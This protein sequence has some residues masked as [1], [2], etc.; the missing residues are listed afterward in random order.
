[1]KP[2]TKL[3]ACALLFL[4]PATSKAQN[5]GQIQ[6]ARAGD[7]AYLYSS[8]T[9][10]EVRAKLQCGEE[11][12]VLN[13][14]D[15]FLF[16]RTDKGDTGYVPLESV[17]MLK[18]AKRG[19]KPAPAALAKKPAAAAPQMLKLFDGTPVRLKL[20]RNVSSSDAHTGDE[21]PFEVT[22]DVVVTG[23]TVIRKGTKASGT[24]TEVAPKGRFGKNGKL[25]LSLTAVRLVDGQPAGLR[26]VQESKSE[27]HGV[28]KVLPV[29]GGKD[30]T[31]AE[32]TEVFG[33]ISGGMQL[34]ASKFPHAKESAVSASG[35]ARP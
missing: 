24:V 3:L 1:M 6:C 33:Y 27:R 19:A 4:V 32:G 26:M 13:R 34:V 11:I 9:S 14:Y 15:N 16:V 18:T 30:I 8:L 35:G 20:G 10:M 7:Y 23:F 12:Q 28:S 22:E 17:S 5:L 31:L 25:T 21:V 29:K 2:I